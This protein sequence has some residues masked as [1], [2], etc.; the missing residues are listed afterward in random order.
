M[1]G[2][3][4]VGN[5]FGGIVNYLLNEKKNPEILDSHGVMLES[6]ESI[7]SS[8]NYQRSMNRNLGKAVWHS[9]ISFAYTD[10]IDTKI[11]KVVANDY[12]NEIGLNDT[13]FLVVKHNDRQH[14]HLHILANR[15]DNK[16]DTVSD[17]FA[18]NRTVKIMQALEKSYELT[19]AKENVNQRK[20]E[21]KNTIKNAI[22]NGDSL[23]QVF[24][25][26]R[27][28][29]YEV[30]KNEDSNNKVTGVSYSMKSKGIIWKASQVDRSLSYLK[31]EKLIENVAKKK[32]EFTPINSEINQNTQA[33]VAAN[34]ADSS[35]ILMADLQTQSMEI[36]PEVKKDL[37]DIKIDDS[38]SKEGKQS[39]V[40]KLGLKSIERDTIQISLF[41]DPTEGRLTAVNEK[42][43]SKEKRSGTNQ[44]IVQK[45]MVAETKSEKTVNEKVSNEQTLENRKDIEAIKNSTDLEKGIKEKK[46]E[47]STQET[48]VELKTTGSSF[49]EEFIPNQLSIFGQK[50]RKVS[51]RMVDNKEPL[52]DNEGGLSQRENSGENGM[53][54]GEQEPHKESASDREERSKKD[55]IGDLDPESKIIVKEDIVSDSQDLVPHNSE[56]DDIVEDGIAESVGKKNIDDKR[57]SFKNNEPLKEDSTFKSS[58]KVSS[59]FIQG[60]DLNRTNKD[61]KTKKVQN[62]GNNFQNVIKENQFTSSKTVI[63]IVSDII[64]SPNLDSIS[65]KLN[66][67]KTQRKYHCSVPTK[68][69]FKQ[70]FNDG[71][72]NG[73][74]VS[75]GNLKVSILTVP[76]FKKYKISGTIDS[77]HRSKSKNF[78]VI[79]VV[80]ENGKNPIVCTFKGQEA[81]K[82]L[83]RRMKLGSKVNATVTPNVLPKEVFGFFTFK[84]ENFRIEERPIKRYKPFKLVPKMFNLF[85][86]FLDLMAYMADTKEYGM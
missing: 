62:E 19:V 49:K 41:D 80:D 32:D 68:A 34:E 22:D 55:Q 51:I 79:S 45:D 48:K 25:K 73:A 20:K 53:G 16:G 39:E 31:M 72:Q 2:K 40:V 28:I 83:D 3:V 10:K 14:K 66:S 13:Q 58:Q 47:K 46:V 9:S 56:E 84:V 44:I 6:K 27:K 23:D 8:F 71:F 65:F 67:N 64:A 21:L 17:S 82:F 70:L 61:F 60:S 1:I 38:E 86:G 85:I 35:G 78:L 11:M 7:I 37:K 42:E 29:G 77:V 30:L 69:C 54:L 63:G 24:E 76:R 74:S 75:V 15:V 59:E 4:S 57:K 18:A 36:L 50:D 5:S 12:M 26:V 33:S 43:E 81:R 52:Y